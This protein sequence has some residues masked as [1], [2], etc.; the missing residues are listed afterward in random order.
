MKRTHGIRH[1]HLVFLK[2][3]LLF[4]E[5]LKKISNNVKNFIEK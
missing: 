2:E 3:E 4:E 1:L 5:I